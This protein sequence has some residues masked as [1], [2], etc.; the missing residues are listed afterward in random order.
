MKTLHIFIICTV[1]VSAKV[2]LIA[3]YLFQKQYKSDNYFNIAIQ[4]RFLYAEEF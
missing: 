4:T 2:W 3:P 1:A